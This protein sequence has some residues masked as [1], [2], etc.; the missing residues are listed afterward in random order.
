MRA[1]LIR[2]LQAKQPIFP[3]IIGYEETV[4]PQVINAILSRHNM[5]LLGCAARRRAGFSGSLTEFLD[6][7]I[8][9]IAGCEIND[10]PF[11]PICRRCRDLIQEHGDA[12]PIG[13]VS[14]DERYVEKLA[15]PDVTIADIIGDIDPIKAAKGGHAIGSEMSVHYGL[16]P[17]ANR[18]IFAI[19]ELPDLAGKI[20]VG[21]FNIMQEGDV[22]IKGYPVRL[23]LDVVLVFSANPED[24][25]ARGKIVTPL[26]DRIGSEIKTHYPATL[27]H[28]VAI[29]EQEAWIHRNSG[30]TDSRP[31]FRQADCRR[32]RVQGPGGPANR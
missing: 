8:P 32:N 11:A 13:I 17:R 24:Y 6:E 10:N 9:V 27:D 1:N 2:K 7:R 18:G 23:P 21:L 20:Q 5:I 28:G 26:K 31:A 15:T 22:Q 12:T 4:V 25:T 19:N 29:T 3:G 14:R 30:R 16:L